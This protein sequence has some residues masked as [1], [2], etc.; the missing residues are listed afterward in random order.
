MGE[1]GRSADGTAGSGVDCVVRFN[2]NRT[3]VGDGSEPWM[4]RPADVGLFHALRH[5]ADAS[6]GT[7]RPGETMIDGRVVRTQ[8]ARAVGVGPFAGEPET[9]NAYRSERGLPFRT[10]Y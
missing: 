6:E 7:V 1:P 3:R 4:A 10:R 8:Q 9:E 2:P 5:A